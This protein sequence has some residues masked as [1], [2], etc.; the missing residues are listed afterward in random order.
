MSNTLVSPGVSISVTDQSMYAGAGPGTVPLIFIATGQ[1]KSDPTGQNPTAPGTSAANAGTVYS[2]TSQR[3]LIATFGNPNFYSISGSSVNGYPLNEYGLLSAYSYLGISNQ[4]LIVRAAVDLNALQPTPIAPTSPAAINT[5]WFDESAAGT[6]YGLF[7][8]SG[9]FPNEVWTSV[10]SAFNYNFLTGTTNTPTSGDGSVGSYASVFQSASGTLSY[11]TK[12]TAG[13]V[14]LG[15]NGYSASATATAAST[16][17]T[18]A[19]TTGLAVGMV[20]TATGTGVFAANTTITAINSSTTFTVS[21][22]PSTPIAISDTIKAR[23]SVVIS[24]VWPDLTSVTTT[25]EFWVKTTSAAAGANLVIR[26]MDATLNAFTQ[27]E[28]PILANDAAANIYY[29]T[30]TTLSNGQIY[31]GPVGSGTSQ[32]DTNSLEFR[33]STGATGPWAPMAGIIGSATAPNSGPVNGQLWYNSL[34]G[35]DSSGNS[36]IDILVS[37][38]VGAWENINLPGF[39]TL[40]VAGGSPTLYIQTQDP[41]SNT[42]IPTLVKGDIWVETAE[43]TVYPTINRWSGTQWILVSNTDQTTPNGIIFQD[44]RPNPLYHTGSYTGQNNEGGSNPDLDPDAPQAALYPKGFLLWNTRFSTNNVKKWN[45]LFVFDSI[46]A[47]A[48]N[49]NGGSLGRWVTTSGNDATGRP[50]MG[51]DAQK[52]IIIEALKSEINTNENILAED[53]FYNLIAAPGFVEASSDMIGLNDSRGDTAFVVGDTPFTLASSGSSLQNWSTNASSALTD[54]NLGL[55]SASKY[56]AA[57]YPSGIGTNTD[58]TNVVVPPSHMA[59]NVIAYNDQVAYPWLAPAG[60]QRG[61]VN[62]A[63]SVGYVT[64]TGQYTPVKLSQGQ[65]DILYTNNINPI[66]TMP[67]GDIVVYGQKTRQPYASATSRINVVRL[68]NYI[69]YQ[70]NAIVQPFFFQPNDS[71]TQAAVRSAVDSF[72]SELVTLRG[73]YDY[74]VVCD[75][76]NNTP[77]RVQANQLW[78][79]IAISPEIAVEFIYIPIRIVNTGASL[80]ASTTA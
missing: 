2:I 56:F 23:F 61:V 36:T 27:V 11:W 42:P 17:I 48:D 6:T 7:V 13:W 73:L 74:L 76:S 37:N 30:T 50:Y 69:R 45:S 43:T 53:L 26:R 71:I 66:R 72:L 55:V 54:G 8:R 59:L 46:T 21:T 79:D 28:A 38:G 33:L 51:S 64:S 34:I 52:I 29:S 60:L 44:A 68:E 12:T 5:Y 70:L 14:Q 32:V 10:T 20:P 80:T 4:C 78:I 49:T 62:N 9:V 15:N 58:G 19:S 67:A 18:V 75:S 35:L 57:W 40:T 63:T 3:D 41:R 24:S 22:A 25:Q 1:D 47:Q 39:S 77:S 16:L 65:R 31:V